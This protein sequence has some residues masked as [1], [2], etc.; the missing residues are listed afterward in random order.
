MFRIFKE[1][2]VPPAPATTG[3]GWQGKRSSAHV[4]HFNWGCRDI[5]GHLLG[6]TWAVDAELRY[7]FPG[8]VYDD[9]IVFQYR[10]VTGQTRGFLQRISGGEHIRDERKQECILSEMVH[11]VPEVLS[12]QI[13]A[14]W[15]AVRERIEAE[16]ALEAFSTKFKTM[17]EADTQA[18][19]NTLRAGGQAKLGDWLNIMKP[20][21]ALFD[22]LARTTADAAHKVD[23]ARRDAERAR[24]AAVREAERKV[25]EDCESARKRLL[26]GPIALSDTMPGSIVLGTAVKTG[27]TYRVELRKLRH[28][29][30]C[31]VSGSGKSV[32]LHE[33]VWQMVALPDFEKIIAIDL[34]GGME[35]AAYRKSDKVQV[36]W[37]F[38]SGDVARAVEGLLRLAEE[39]Q[40]YMRENSLRNWPD[41]G[42]VALVIDEFAEVQSAIDTASEK[43]EK[44]RA[45]RLAANMV[46]LAR[47]ARA[48]GIHIIIAAQKHTTDSI[49]SALLN[50]LNWRLVLRQGARHSARA[51]LDI[52]DDFDALPVP[53]TELPDGRFYAYDTSTGG[54][55]LLQAHV[56]PGVELN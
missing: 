21:E 44:A 15:K 1:L 56:A 7:P 3:P 6:E 25:A 29:L 17:V 2:F 33:I 26:S 54:L 48:L 14:A 16:R 5:P 50:N 42:R 36:V 22:N 30:L 13:W 24:E 10:L 52:D 18:V 19:I 41:H 37:D 23:A 12:K 49:D 46:S 31:G 43:E 32:L 47:R 27:D 28:L 40:A 45:K 35:F 8:A 20:P 9:K 11:R 55:N 39:R 51:L 34:K 38:E 4:A 53:P